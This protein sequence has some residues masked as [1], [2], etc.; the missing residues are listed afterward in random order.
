MS[1]WDSIAIDRGG[2]SFHGRYR[3]HHAG[4]T[5]EYKGYER[6]ALLHAS[7]AETLARIILRELVDLYG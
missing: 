7:P 2:R 4:L 6:F 5:V 1:N 3:L